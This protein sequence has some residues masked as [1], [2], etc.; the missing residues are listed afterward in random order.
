MGAFKNRELGAMEIIVIMEIP[1]F[2]GVIFMMPDF[3]LK[4]FLTF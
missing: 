2:W 1:T 4:P 3:R